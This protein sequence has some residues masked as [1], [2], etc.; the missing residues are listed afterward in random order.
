MLIKIKNSD[1]VAKKVDLKMVPV[2]YNLTGDTVTDEMSGEKHN[3]CGS[4]VF[5]EIAM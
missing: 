4:W 2:V 5:K 3:F 1:K